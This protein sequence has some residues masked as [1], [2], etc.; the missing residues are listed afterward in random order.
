MDDNVLRGIGKTFE[1]VRAE[2]HAYQ[3]A[4]A[5]N[6]G[7]NALYVDLACDS[8]IYNIISKQFTLFP[9]CNYLND[10]AFTLY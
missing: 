5:I 8:T 2:I 7:M 1:D 6:N 4:T 9:P 3:K 10:R